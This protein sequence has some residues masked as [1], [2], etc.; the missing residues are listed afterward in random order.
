MLLQTV[1]VV[2]SRCHAGGNRQGNVLHLMTESF[3]LWTE[4]GANTFSVDLFEGVPVVTPGAIVIVHAVTAEAETWAQDLRSE[5]REV[6]LTSGLAAQVSAG[7]SVTTAD[8][9][10]QPCFTDVN[11]QKLLVIVCDDSAPLTDRSWFSQ[12]QT[13]APESTI[14]VFPAGANP[15]AL[16]PSDDLRKIN[17]SFW[18]KSVTEAV[19]A[20]LSSAG[21]TAEEHRVFVSYRR[22]E[23]EPIA[24]QLF[25]RLTHEGFELFLDRFSIEPGVDFQRRL[26]QELADKAMVVLLESACIASSRWTQHEIDYTKRFRLGLLALRLPISTPLRSIDVDLRYQLRRSHFE[27]R[28]LVVNNPL[29]R[30]A[31]DA[32]KEPEKLLRWGH[33]TPAA[34]DDVVARIKWTHDHAIFRRR[35]YLRDTMAT[36]LRSVGVKK[37]SLRTDGLLVAEAVD[38]SNLYSIWM[39]T[40]P[41]EIGDFHTAHPKTL[42]KPLSK[43]VVIGPTALLESR[44]K[45]RLD[46]LG[47]L[48]KFECLDE[49]EISATAQKI[50]EGTL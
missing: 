30:T 31:A 9:M 4:A 46:W 47:G 26:N 29:Y 13:A 50:K 2:G 39:T 34:L 15:A 40:R 14:P 25:D 32:G 20:I 1:G 44:R 37:A 27:S 3:I 43:G 17:V 23:T 8:P 6:L 48:C 21:L 24:E 19:P 12:W 28:P 36:A 11:R 45:D 35:H 33:L 5:L 10:T 16:L 42:I 7:G 41:P 18:S 49:S 22:V 38:N